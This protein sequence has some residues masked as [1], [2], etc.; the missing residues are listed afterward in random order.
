MPKSQETQGLAMVGQT[1]EDPDQEFARVLTVAKEA[2]KYVGVFRTPPTPSI[3]E[4]WYRYVEGTDSSLHDQ[5]SHA[6]TI[7][8]SVSKHQLEFLHQQLLADSTGVSAVDEVRNRL[9][10]EIES[11][12]QLVASQLDSTQRF[13]ESLRTV[14]STLGDT[15]ATP[16]MIERCVTKLITNNE[17]MQQQLTRMQSHMSESQRQIGDLKEDLLV[18]QRTAITDSLT[19]LGNRRHFDSSARHAIG[20]RGETD[21][22]VYMVLID[23]DRLK[24]IN[25]K[26]GSLVGD[27]ILKYTA[28]AIQATFQNATLSRLRSDEFSVIIR[29][30]YP[31]QVIEAANLLRQHFA[32]KDFRSV[33][34]GETLGQVSVSIGAAQLRSSDDERTW[35]DRANKLLDSAKNSG[36]NQAMVERELLAT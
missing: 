2:L 17:Q 3:Y 21:S 7:S 28:K 16:F 29:V 1:P 5:L 4:V 12:T 9:V 24:S 11:L 32:G 26:Y 33:R 34:A 18:A 6:V 22:L 31:L 27:D 13:D 14:Q 35:L 8:K 15:M 10:E 30:E 36:G 20:H 23:V 25:D 19:G